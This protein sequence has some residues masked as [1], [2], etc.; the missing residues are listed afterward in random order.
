LE[1]V[2]GARLVGHDIRV[3][4]LPEQLGQH[5]GGVRAQAYAER[6]ALPLR[7]AAALDRV[8][9][10][11]GLLVEV[12]GLEPPADAVAVHLDAQS[13]ALVH[14]HRERLSAAHPAEAGRER[15]RARQ[16]ALEAPPC[17]LREAL[18]G[19]LHD[20]LAADVDP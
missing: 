8:G 15:D 1:R 13:D 14:R 3:E 12:A 9:Q 6:P 11:V 17:D 20:P 19:A 10:V 5:L 16:R 2:V 18:V 4:A 7:A